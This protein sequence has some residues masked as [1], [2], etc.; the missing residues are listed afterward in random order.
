MEI[1]MILALER[2][3]YILC[4]FW[5]FVDVLITEKKMYNEKLDIFKPNEGLEPQIAHSL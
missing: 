3:W 1:K 2:T 5:I 4:D